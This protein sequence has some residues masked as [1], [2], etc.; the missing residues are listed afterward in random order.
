MKA[1][2]HAYAN[3]YQGSGNDSRLV[4]FSFGISV[5]IHLVFLGTLIFFPQSGSNNR[6]SSSVVM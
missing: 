4:G 2:K 1:T 3:R 6:F 5:A